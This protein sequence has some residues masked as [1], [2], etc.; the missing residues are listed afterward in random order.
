MKKYTIGLIT[1]ALLAISAMMFI[2]AQNKNLGDITVTSVSVVNDDG[3]EVG[4]LESYQDTGFLRLSRAGKT[5]EI[6][7]V[8]EDVGGAI[9][10]Y[11]KDGKRT[12]FLGTDVEGGG[13]I[14]T[15]KKDGKQT[16]GLGNGVSGGGS[17]I[18]SNADGKKTAYLGTSEGG[19][20]FLSTYNKH[21]VMTGYFGT[22][23][24]N[25]G[26]AVLSD[27]YG[28]IGWAVDGKK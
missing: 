10:T 20:G 21:E 12:A 14:S 13:T 2:G 7:L 24:D 22:N 17:I 5:A 1:G 27:R 25:D 26:M 11:N 23:T 4:R 16:V 19:F 6:M 3:Y 28:D 8:V 18:T 15:Y 9:S